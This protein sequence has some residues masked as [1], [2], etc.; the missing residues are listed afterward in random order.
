MSDDLRFLWQS[1][2]KSFAAHPVENRVF[3]LF[4]NHRFQLRL[5]PGG[6]DL[7]HVQ[8][9]RAGNHNWFIL[10]VKTLAGPLTSVSTLEV[11]VLT[12]KCSH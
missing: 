8:T 12:Q 3:L 9:F 10:N 1:Q 2:E 11:L 6:A 5:T 7:I 4:H